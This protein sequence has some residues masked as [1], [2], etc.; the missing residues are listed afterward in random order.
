MWLS[1]RS[2]GY[3]L[4]LDCRRNPDKIGVVMQARMFSVFKRL[5]KTIDTMYIP[6][7]CNWQ[8]SFSAA[9]FLFT[10]YVQCS[11]VCL[12]SGVPF[13]LSLF[14]EKDESGFLCFFLDC[15]QISAC[16]LQADHCIKHKLCLSL[17]SLLR[18]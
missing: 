12:T 13:F 2:T 6:G 16:L 18:T 4:C 17:T 14:L 10:S 7:R 3:T 8:S 11:M 1:C 9:S 5:T 15:G